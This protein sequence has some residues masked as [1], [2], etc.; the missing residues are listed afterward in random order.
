[1]IDEYKDWIMGVKPDL[2]VADGPPLYAYGFMMGEEDLNR[3]VKN[4]SEI[5]TVKPKEVIWDH[6]LCRGLFRE[7]L[8]K[9]Y[10]LAKENKVRLCTAAEHMGKKPL[11][12]KL[13]RK[14]V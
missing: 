4:M 10:S 12:E 14:K 8:E 6:H 7:K 2:I 5:L 11:I 1:M 9:V 3:V 13:K